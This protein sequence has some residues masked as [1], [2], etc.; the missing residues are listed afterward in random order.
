MLDKAVQYGT[1][2]MEATLATPTLQKL[3]G[4]ENEAEAAGPEV[5]RSIGPK[6]SSGSHEPLKS[7][8]QHLLTLHTG[9]HCGLFMWITG[10]ACSCFRGE[11]STNSGP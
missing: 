9:L 11:T 2:L 8:T 4:R 10:P 6:L 1:S 3:P 7:H 5:R